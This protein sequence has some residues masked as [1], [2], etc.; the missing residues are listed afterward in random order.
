[1]PAPWESV[2]ASLPGSWMQ[3]RGGW[4]RYTLACA[5][6]VRR[7]SADAQ[8]P[9]VPARAR[10]RRRADR[11]AGRRRRP[12]ALRRGRPA[13]P[14]RAGRSQGRAG[15]RRGDA[16]PRRPAHRRPRRP[17]GRE[18]PARAAGDGPHADRQRHEGVRRRGGAAAGP[19]RTARARRHDRRAPAN[20]AAGVVGRDDPPTAQPHEWR[21]GLFEVRRLRRRARDR[22]RRVH[23]ARADHRLG[24]RGSAR[25]PA[26]VQIR[27]LE[28]GQHHRRAD[29][30][31]PD[32]TGVPG[33][34]CRG[35]LR[36]RAAVRDDV[37]HPP[38]HAAR[39]VP[40]RLRRRR[41]LHVAHQ[42]QRRV[43]VRRH[44]LHARRHERVHARL[45]R[46]PLLRR[47]TAA[48]ADA[49][50]PRRQIQPARA[51][52]QQCGP[53]AVPVPDTLRNRLWAH[54]ELPGLRPV[55]GRDGG[56]A[57]G[58]H[59]LAEHPRPD[60]AA[61]G[62]LARGA[63]QGGL[64]AAPVIRGV[65]GWRPSDPGRFALRLAVRTG[66]VLPLALALG[67]SVGNEQPSV[68]AG[69]GT[70]KELVFADFGGPRRV[71]LAAYLTLGV[72]SSALI[73]L[74]TL[75]SRHAVVAALAMFVVGFA[76]LFSGVVNGYFAAAASAA[77]LTF[78][79][80][81]L[82]PAGVGDIGARLA[83]W[84]IAVAVSV[85][86]TFLIL[87]ARPRD[88]L[89]AA[90]AAAGRA[91]AAY[92][93]DATP[94]HAGTLNAAHDELQ[95]RFAS[96]PFRHTGPTGAT[97]ALAAIIDELEWLRGLVLRPASSGATLDPTPGE[98][99]LR[100]VS[101][102]ALLASA[103]LVEG[104][105]ARRPDSAA[106]EAG[107][108]RAMDELV[109]QLR[110]PAV[111]DDDERLWSALARAWDVRVI[112][113]LTLHLAENAV[114]AGGGAPAGEGPPVLRFVRRQGVSLAASRRLA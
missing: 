35:R 62:P 72:A 78:I 83:G 107:R 21:S 77:L 73:A 17:R 71:Q 111:R 80:P 46:P 87:P 95:D 57:P 45:S 110:H 53:R 52:A 104:R 27:I 29:R 55:R 99:A 94:E 49:L 47:G 39:P 96:T 59:H 19:G 15:W 85:P 103:A 74:G 36:A 2:P 67:T 70:K 9:C 102:D 106:V 30:R 82:V 97:G 4:R 90:V 76:I 41:G 114:V 44:R 100:D 38:A 22:S 84:W 24:A 64:R 34:A 16:V 56:R 33:P 3:R 79:L 112:S 43:G 81:A 42:P 48:P 11:G 5:A 23:H 40:P 93:R 109:G 1:M 28:H 61:A 66:V 63:D 12:C 89:R 91:L 101:A 14:R 69:L 6:P 13:R 105:S 10:R 31:G 18:T 54:G 98:L 108:D 8:L 26:R 25:L 58:G 51:R 65:L 37:P 50:L 75:C 32:R 92:V 60:R 68:V 113:Y 86:A 20:H 88:R 7:G